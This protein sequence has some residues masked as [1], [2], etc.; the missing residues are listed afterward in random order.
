MRK[1]ELRTSGKSGSDDRFDH[2]ARG[3]VVERGR[4]FGVILGSAAC[5]MSIENN[6]NSAGVVRAKSEVGPLPLG[7]DAETFAAFLEGKSP[8]I[9]D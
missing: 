8:S 2:F 7:L 9:S 3:L 4:R 1:V 5:S 6:P